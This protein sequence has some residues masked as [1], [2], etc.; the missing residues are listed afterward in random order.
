ME[1]TLKN[2]GGNI[3]YRNGSFF[4]VFVHAGLFL[5]TAFAIWLLI[6]Y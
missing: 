6:N 3:N 4:N 5:N 1:K 2:H